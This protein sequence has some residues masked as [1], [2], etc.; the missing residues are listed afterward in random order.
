[1]SGEE[2]FLDRLHEAGIGAYWGSYS[3]LDRYFDI[4]KLRITK[5]N[6]YYLVNSTWLEFTQLFE[7]IEFNVNPL[8]DIVVVYRENQYFVKFF[9]PDD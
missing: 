7:R 4:K 2:V 3:A 5:G 6:S 8:V 9:D 1:M